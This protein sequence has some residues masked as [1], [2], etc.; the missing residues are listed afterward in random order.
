MRNRYPYADS[1]SPS[2]LRIVLW[3]L[4]IAIIAVKTFGSICGSLVKTVNGISDARSR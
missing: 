3:T 2:S 1:S 4:A